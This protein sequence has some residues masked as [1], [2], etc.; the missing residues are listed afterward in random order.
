[1]T[2]ASDVV[3]VA[4][5]HPSP[6][7][8]AGLACCSMDLHLLA[9]SMTLHADLYLGEAWR[10][11]DLPDK[12]LWTVAPGIGSCAY[13]HSASSRVFTASS[14]RCR[15]A[16]QGKPRSAMRCQVQN[17]AGTRATQIYIAPS[18]ALLANRIVFRVPG[19]QSRRMFTERLEGVGTTF[20]PPE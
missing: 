1:M 3:A 20:G 12:A 19:H 13:S 7:N 15:P 17:I 14:I 2:A 6:T 9:D 5:E 18:M 16:L 10:S 11:R 4:V 8:N